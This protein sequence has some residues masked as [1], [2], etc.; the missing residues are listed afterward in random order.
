MSVQRDPE[1]GQFVAVEGQ[2]LEG[3][4]ETTA[5]T[6]W[7][8]GTIPAAD[9]AGGTTDQDQLVG[10]EVEL[11]DFSGV[12]AS[13][14]VFEVVQ[15]VVS[16]GLWIHT[17]NTAEAA[18]R[19][20]VVVSRESDLNDFRASFWA[21]TP[22]S[23]QGVWDVQAGNLERAEVLHRSHLFTTNQYGDSTNGLGAGS[24]IDRDRR[25][26]PF[27]ALYG[28]G[29]MFDQDDEL[30]APMTVETDNISDS[31]L[32][33]EVVVHLRGVVHQL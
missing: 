1:T 20:Q 3:Y 23:E 27:R 22:D 24:D 2:R 4:H 28:S 15:M 32:E 10:E 16:A 11:V 30:Y 31:A 6:G 19:G 21:G 33:Q 12:L 25:T 14:E 13:D 17:T 18:A 9:L 8:S 5:L 26:Y 7:V 29:P